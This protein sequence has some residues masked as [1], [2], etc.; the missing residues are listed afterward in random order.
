VSKED[1]NRIQDSLDKI[2]DLLVDYNQRL[3]RCET[4]LGGYGKIGAYLVGPLCVGA[5]LL[6]LGMYLK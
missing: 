4:L 1:I 5:L 2:Y 3:T 6:L